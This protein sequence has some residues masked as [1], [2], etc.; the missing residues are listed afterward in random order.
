VENGVR[1]I[2]ALSFLASSKELSAEWFIPPD[3]GTVEK[4]RVADDLLIDLRFSANG[5]DL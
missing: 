1:I 3:D 2:R 5:R 4:I